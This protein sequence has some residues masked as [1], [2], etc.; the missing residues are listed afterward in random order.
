MDEFY[1][2]ADCFVFTSKADTFGVV[3]IESMFCGTP[4]AGYP[5]QGPIDII[6][7][8]YTGYTNENLETAIEKCLLLSRKKCS[9]IAKDSW[10]WEESYKTFVNNLE[11]DR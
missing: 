10:S 6:D 4:V 9:T 11:R 2:T 8:K 7:N 3:I 1:Q 5:V